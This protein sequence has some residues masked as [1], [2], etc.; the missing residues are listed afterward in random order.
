[1][2]RYL[3]QRF[4]TRFHM[5]LIL[6]S[7]GLAAMLA[8]WALL[9]AGVHSMLVRYPVATGVAYFT[10][11]SGVWLWL[12]YAGLGRGSGAGRDLLES[13]DIPDI[14]VGGGSGGSGPGSV[15]GLGRGG[16]TFDGGGA[17]SSWAE[18]RTPALPAGGSASHGG[19]FSLGDFGDLDGDAIALLAM[20]LAVVAAIFLASGYLIWFAPDI[21]SEAAFGALLAGGLAR[22]SKRE[23]AA[24]WMAGVAKK[25]WWPFAIVLAV[26]IAFAWYCANHYPQARTFKEAVSMALPA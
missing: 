17:S 21:L 23:D 24:G 16:G 8:S 7:S 1:V 15:G 2:K 9:H 26:A 5:S 11:L 25:T 12:R 13:A 3:V 19:G 14:P 6:S 10:F 20:A 22:R 18:A 4:Y